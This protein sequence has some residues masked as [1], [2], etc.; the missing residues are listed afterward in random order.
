VPLLAAMLLSGLLTSPGCGGGSARSSRKDDP[1]TI[2]R[3]LARPTCSMTPSR[4]VVTVPIRTTSHGQDTVEAAVCV[5]GRGPYDFI[6]DTG[7]SG[8]LVTAQLARRLALP[9]IGPSGPFG[10][11]G[12]TGRTHPVLLPS[13]S[14][15]G[16]TIPGGS[17]YV[18]RAN[19]LGGQ[20]Q[21]Q[22]ALGVS[23][24]AKLGSLRLD[25]QRKTLTIGM[26]SSTHT[27]LPTAGPRAS[28]P[29][30]WLKRPPE[31]R[32]PLALLRRGGGLISLRVIVSLDGGPPQAWLPDTG[33]QSSLVDPTVARSSE[34]PYLH[35][36][37][38]QPSACSRKPLHS[39]RVWS[40]HWELAGIPLQPQSLQVSTLRPTVGV[41]GVIGAITLAE[42]GSD[43]FDWAGRRLL[44]G[45]G[46]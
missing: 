19:G 26:P 11:A 8:T 18:I 12:C 30:D 34:L 42:Y 17:A 1:P 5:G 45:V 4:K 20:G 36:T 35:G 24:L 9:A 38:T 44:L 41:E 27:G 2:S 39:R 16:R 37:L 23:T 14:V 7:G 6:I 46:K 40:G 43:V 32:A 22:G 31:V 15:G 28:I 13:V 25:Y 10:G 29:N 3:Q 33:A 21:P